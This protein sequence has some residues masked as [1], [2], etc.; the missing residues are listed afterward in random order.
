M[1]WRVLGPVGAAAGDR[2]TDLGGD[3]QRTIAAALLA[4]RG[5]AVTTDRLIDGLWGPR[6]P[7]SARKTLQSYVSR[8]RSELRGLDPDAA[9]A[10][11]SPPTGT[12]WTPG[13]ASS[14]PMTSKRSS[15]RCSDQGSPSLPN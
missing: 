12:A 11:A 5:E 1:R 6:P 14:T 13:P 10:V 4:A 2:R 8:L 9:D 15:R 7:P 3:R